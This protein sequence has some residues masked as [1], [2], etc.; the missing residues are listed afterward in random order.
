MTVAVRCQRTSCVLYTAEYETGDQYRIAGMLM[1]LVFDQPAIPLGLI[2][3]FSFEGV[4]GNTFLVL[5]VGVVCPKV[6]PMG[7]GCRTNVCPGEWGALATP[8]TYY[9][10]L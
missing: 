8:R 10:V 9:S 6:C 5:R 3:K 2:Q 1:L 4:G 7:D